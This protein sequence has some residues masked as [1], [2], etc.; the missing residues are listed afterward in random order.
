MLDLASKLRRDV[1]GATAVEYA[2][3]ASFIG[4]ALIVCFHFLG[5]ELTF[6][7]GRLGDAL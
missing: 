3:A 4:I 6:T 7:F 1:G 2:L 5:V